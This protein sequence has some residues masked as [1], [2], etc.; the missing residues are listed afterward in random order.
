VEKK[1]PIYKRWWFWA[2]I[3]LIII[4]IGNMGND[5]QTNNDQVA[6]EQEKTD[7]AE[8][9][10]QEEQKEEKKQED[11]AEW[12]PQ[13]DSFGYVYVHDAGNIQT[14][15]VLINVDSFPTLGVT[16]AREIYEKL[17]NVENYRGSGWY[18]VGVDI[19]AGQYTIES[20][21][22]G[23]VAIMSGPVGNNEIV[24]NEIFNGK[25]T[26][27]VSNGQYLQVTRGNILQ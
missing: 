9:E 16:S 24:N 6:N 18:K 22:Q 1:K 19:P 8:K 15:G 20:T 7:V 14:Q 3:I 17:N 27:N 25:Y 23:Y 4:A 11:K 13:F 2:L 12:T 10:T 26:V 5:E 21:G